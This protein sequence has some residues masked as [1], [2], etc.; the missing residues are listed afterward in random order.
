MYGVSCFCKVNT[1]LVY[2]LGMLIDKRQHAFFWNRMN[3]I[4]LCAAVAGR[5]GK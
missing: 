3:L 2:L 5:R 1:L 4:E